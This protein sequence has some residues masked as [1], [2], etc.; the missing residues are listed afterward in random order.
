MRRLLALV[1]LLATLPAASAAGSAGSLPPPV[2]CPGCWH[3]ALRT[4]W[5]WQL[6]TV[7]H[8]P[9][10]DVDMY[11]IDVFDTPASTVAALHASKPGR[12]VTCYISAGSWES[13]RPDAG[14]FPRSLLGKPLDHW[15]GER[16]LDIRRFN[17]AL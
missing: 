4:S 2:P 5:Q 1:A 17:G 15:P 6:S 10:L 12:R 14:Q 13:W 7:P 9:F 3:P 8:A 11:D 16:Y